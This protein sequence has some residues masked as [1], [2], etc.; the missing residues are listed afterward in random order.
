MN[1]QR[2]EKAIGFGPPGPARRLL[3]VRP[4]TDSMGINSAGVSITPP[5]PSFERGGSRSVVIAGMAKRL[6][7]ERPTR[8][9]RKS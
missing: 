7:G 4:P 9:R 1:P 8:T 3:V 6:L 5:R 2:H